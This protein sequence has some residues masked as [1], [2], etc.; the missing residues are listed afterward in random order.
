M[1]MRLAL[2]MILLCL[3]GC[4]MGK[5]IVDVSNDPRFQGGYR[6]GQTYRLRTSGFL[7]TPSPGETWELWTAAE[8]AAEPSS[9][10]V[11]VPAG[12]TVR[13]VRL[14]YLYD[15]YHPPVTGGQL[16]MLFAYGRLKF[17]S[18]M[19]FPSQ[20]LVLPKLRDAETVPG[21]SVQ[22]FPVDGEFLDLVG[23]P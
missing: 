6:V 4:A 5:R 16:E 10:A 18:R 11:A 2:A 15:D 8:E 22:V 7:V 17:G 21:T 19:E 12:S 3:S 1:N 23:S 14:G 20:V 13:I 9:T